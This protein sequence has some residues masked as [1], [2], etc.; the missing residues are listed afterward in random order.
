MPTRTIGRKVGG[1]GTRR[2]AF[3]G[4]QSASAHASDRHCLHDGPWHHG[5]PRRP[6]HM[7]SI[8]SAILQRRTPGLIAEGAPSLPGRCHRYERIGFM[9]LWVA[10]AVVSAAVLAAVLPPLGGPIPV[11]EEAQS[12]TLNVY[13][14]Q[15]DELVVEQARGLVDPTEAA[16]A[17]VEISRR[18]LTSAAQFEHATPRGS[19]LPASC[20]GRWSRPARAPC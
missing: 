4:L 16:A 12:G 3:A 6:G 14:N 13:R 9:L 8:G 18:L 15:L 2:K 19:C 17:K 5:Q 1:C 10:F 20:S 7:K 11:E